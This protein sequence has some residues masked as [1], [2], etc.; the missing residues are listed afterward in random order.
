MPQADDEQRSLME[1]W[2]GDAVSDEGPMFFLYARGWKFPAGI[3]TPPTPAHQPSQYEAACI[4]FLCDE[5]DYGFN[6]V[7]DLIRTA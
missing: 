7:M 2:F 6:G 4:R 1:K 3:C 5:W